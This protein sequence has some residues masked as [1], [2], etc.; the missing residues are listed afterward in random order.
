MIRAALFDMDGLLIDS[1]RIYKQG[2]KAVMGDLGI[3]LSDETLLRSMGT[4]RPV[5]DAIFAE[6]NP[7]YDGE[8]LHEALGKYLRDHGYDKA[9]PLM[10]YAGEILRRL[11]A[12][13]IACALVT[14][15]S[16]EHAEAYMT[17][18]GLLPLFSAIVTGDMKLTGK[19]APDV[20]LRA[21]E[22]LNVDIGDCA[23]LEDSYN[24][25]RAGRAAG[26]VTIMVPDQAPYVPEIAGCCDHVA[27]DLR[28]A[29]EII[30]R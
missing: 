4:P 9:M 23:V 3:C 11:N 13:G 29:E 19:P 5:T 17:S 2:F 27:R 22:M 15:S 7:N 14:S 26:A 28:E 21:A 6:N 25:L 30:C 12:R 10:P 20:Y 18:A 24:G 1:E 8:K 16:R